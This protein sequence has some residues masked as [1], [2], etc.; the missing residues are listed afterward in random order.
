MS[1]VDMGAPHN[2]LFLR[3]EGALQAWGN[4]ESKFVIRRTADVPTKSGIAGLLC[5]ALGIGRQDAVK[6]WLP[7]LAN[8]R[9]G[10]RIDRPGIRWWDFQTVGAGQRMRKA[11]FKEPKTPQDVGEAL[12]ATIKPSQIQTREETLPSRREYLCDA[13]FLV[14]LQGDPE[15]IAQL[16]HAI[17]NPK[18]TLYLGRK[19]CSPSRP[20][21]EHGTGYYSSLEEALSSLPVESRD[22]EDACPDTVLCVLDWIPACDGEPAPPEAEVHYDVPVAFEPPRHLPR[23]VIRKALALACDIDTTRSQSVKTWRPPRPRADYK[24][25]KYKEVRAERLVMDRGLCMV[26]KAPATTVQHV[27]YRRAGGNEEPEDL[28]ALCRLCHDACTMLEYGSGMAMDRIDPCDPAWRDR[29]LEK[30]K[31]ILEFRSLEQRRRKLNPEEE[32]G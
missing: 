7:I 3:L 12:E 18:W 32:N 8:L 4:N 19:C 17:R 15:I 2:T 14:A 24:N 9:M 25:S 10:V 28:R 27:N 22:G 30:R 13:S 21:G 29:I 6:N 20:V 26:C 11:E 1:A 31:E 16:S 23:F 5:A